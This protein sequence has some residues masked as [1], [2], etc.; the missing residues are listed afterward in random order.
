MR[1]FLTFV[2]CL[3]LT[4]QDS[5]SAADA[6][7]QRFTFT[8]T[9]GWEMTTTLDP[10]LVDRI[11]GLY[12]AITS[13]D[14]LARVTQPRTAGPGITQSEVTQAEISQWDLDVG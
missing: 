4:A 10:A 1:T 3:P 2:L 6:A 7:H 12:P 5:P 9:Q 14:V 13:R 11:A 8:C